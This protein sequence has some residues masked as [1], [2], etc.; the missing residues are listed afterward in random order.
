ME[1]AVLDGASR[2]GSNTQNFT[3]YSQTITATLSALPGLTVKPGKVNATAYV[4]V[5]VQ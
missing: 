3:N 2:N 1:S 4:L 5:K